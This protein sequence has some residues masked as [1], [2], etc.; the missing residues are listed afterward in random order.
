[1]AVVAMRSAP[2]VATNSIVAVEK[3][4][5]NLSDRERGVRSLYENVIDPRSVRQ[6]APRAFPSSFPDII[7]PLLLG[8]RLLGRHQNGPVQSHRLGR[9]VEGKFPLTVRENR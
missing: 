2:S 8:Q 5:V 4:P 6:D 7:G 1:M 3:C 9:V